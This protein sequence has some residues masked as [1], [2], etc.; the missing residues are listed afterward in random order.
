MPP[1]VRNTGEVSA[2]IPQAPVQIEA[3]KTK[4]IDTKDQKQEPPKQ[5]AETAAKN[6]AAAKQHAHDIKN[7]DTARVQIIKNQLEQKLPEKNAPTD[8]LHN[9]STTSAQTLK[10]QL[11][12]RIKHG[13]DG[14]KI[15][16]DTPPVQAGPTDNKGQQAVQNE[17]GDRYEIGENMAEKVRKN[18]ISPEGIDDTMK[19]VPA[20]E[21]R[22]VAWAFT[23]EL[24]NEQLENLAAS[25]KGESTLKKMEGHLIKGE[26]DPKNPSRGMDTSEHE[27][28][29]RI[30]TALLHKTMNDKARNSLKESDDFSKLSEATQKEMLEAL[31]SNY[32]D[33][34]YSEEVK[35]K[36]HTV[37]TTESSQ[38]K[39]YF[40]RPEE[41]RREIVKK[42]YDPNLPQ[43]LKNLADDSSFQNLGEAARAKVIKDVTKF[44]RTSSYR[45]MSQAHGSKALDII[46]T[47]SIDAE[48]KNSKFPTA[49]NTVKHLVDGSVPMKLVSKSNSVGNHSGSSIAGEAK[50]R[51]I[52]FNIGNPDLL[53]NPENIATTAAH[54]VNHIVNGKANGQTKDGTVERFLD[55]YRSYFMEQTAIDIPPGADTIFLRDKI[56]ELTSGGTE[57]RQLHTLYKENSQFKAIVDDM[58]RGLNTSPPRITTPEEL[59]SKLRALPGGQKSPY[60]NKAGNLDNH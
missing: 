21:R 15:L 43:A 49:R 28:A 2:P 58:S 11:A 50:I 53:S 19:K 31:K 8:D 13:S 41:A 52:E 23:K 6:A 17:S 14:H 51:S 9:N 46:A 25:E 39:I 4:G 27:Q 56:K 10:D 37:Q 35:K 42:M 7:Q 1:Q 44:A 16:K 47:L 12:E 3:P 18:S 34:K 32:R 20:S 29:D 36:S 5:D 30:S 45:E 33:P 55:E 40:E 60:L 22:D 24:S 57:Y 26:N 54:E 59:R 48:D 38:D